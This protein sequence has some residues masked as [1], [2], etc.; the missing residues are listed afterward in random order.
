MVGVPGAVAEVDLH[1]LHPTRE[2]DLLGA[3]VIGDRCRRVA[4]DIGGLIR[5]EQHRD[6]CVHPPFTHPVAVDVER[7]VAAFA[8]AS[9]VVGELDPHLM[10]PGGQRLFAVHLELL[11]ARRSCSS[12]RGLTVVDVRRSSRRTHRPMRRRLRA[13]GATVRDDDARRSPR[14][15][16]FFIADD[17]VLGEPSHPAEQDAGVLPSISCRAAGEVRR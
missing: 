4:A 9:A 11:H 10:L 7:D 2:M 15:D 14:D 17:R 5:R 3:K 1:P 13:A 8:K 6:R 16:L 12:K